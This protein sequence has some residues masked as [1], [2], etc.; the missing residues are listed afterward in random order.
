MDLR[1]GLLRHRRGRERFVS[2]LVA[3]GFTEAEMERWHAAFER[4][5]PEEHQRFLE[6]LC[7]PEGEI[8]AIR[9]WSARRS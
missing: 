1:D 4:T 8:R 5:S 7:I 9:E 2:A 3:G 6:F